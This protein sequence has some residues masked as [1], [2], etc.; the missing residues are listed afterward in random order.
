MNNIPR[1]ANVV[2]TDG[3][4]LWSKL[5]IEDALIEKV[6]LLL[7]VT[8]LCRV[9]MASAV[10]LRFMRRALTWKK[11]LRQFFPEYFSNDLSNSIKRRLAGAL[12]LEESHEKFK[13][14]LR[15]IYILRQNWERG[16]FSKKRAMLMDLQGQDEEHFSA[17]M[18]TC[19]ALFGSEVSQR[20]WFFSDLDHNS[21]NL[22]H[23]AP[24][25]IIK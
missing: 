15:D 4:I 5:S 2:P 24:G 23:M 22:H 25:V 7:D 20:G 10:L 19:V 9:E 12:A 8:T 6:L 21:T 16:Q 14:I 17:V 13:T 1:I 11:K 3:G 18:D